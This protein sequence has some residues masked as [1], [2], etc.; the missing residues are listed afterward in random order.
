[1]E[2]DMLAAVDRVA[3]GA[4]ALTARA[5][6]EEGADLTLAQWR[7]LVIVGESRDGATVKEIALRL[8]TKPSPT[9]RLVGRLRRRDLVSS[10]RDDPDGRFTRVRLT[11]SGSRLRSQVLRRRERYLRDVLAAVGPVPLD[12][13]TLDRVASALE[14]FA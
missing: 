8:G 13:E 3:V 9:S 4:V 6:S 11:E 2:D 5:V 14:T 7:V 1:M 10:A 12:T